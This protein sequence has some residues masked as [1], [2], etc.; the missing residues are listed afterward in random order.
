MCIGEMRPVRGRGSPFPIIGGTLAGAINGCALAAG[1]DDFPETTQRLAALWANLK[2]SNV[3]RCDLATQAQN[4]IAW[5]MDLSFGGLMGGGNARSLLDATPLR[6][7]LGA[8]LDC[9]RI[10]LNIKRGYLYAVAIA[11]TNYNSG[12]SYLFI[13]GKKGHLMW[14]RRRRVTL[15]T[16][17]TIEHICASAAYR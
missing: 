2:P 12:K 3:F 1:S 9:S 15:S 4:S 8:H 17:I 10:D 16:K 6:H 5:I 11:A 14:N 7:F 13:Q